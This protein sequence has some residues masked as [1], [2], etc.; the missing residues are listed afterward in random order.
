MTLLLT[1]SPRAWQTD[2][3]AE[4]SADAGQWSYQLLWAVDE[5]CSEILWSRTRTQ[6][7][8]GDQGDR[9]PPVLRQPRLHQVHHGPGVWGDFH[10]LTLKLDLDGKLI[11]CRLKDFKDLT[12]K[13]HCHVMG[14]SAG[15]PER[16][17]SVSPHIESSP[18][19]SSAGPQ[20]FSLQE[21]GLVG[22][23]GPTLVRVLL[24][25]ETDR[26]QVRNLRIFF[27][28]IVF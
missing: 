27:P 11:S 18:S 2:H 22:F 9:V 15:T 20:H 14:D 24:A 26:L 28:Q 12:E 10:H 4:L 6:T 23:L 19:H 3:W 13:C 8:L 17:Q 5:V 7:W 1:V 16:R 25:G 21:T